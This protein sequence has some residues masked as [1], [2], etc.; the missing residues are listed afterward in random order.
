MLKVRSGDADPGAGGDLPAIASGPT[1]SVVSAIRRAAALYAVL[2]AVIAALALAALGYLVAQS[3]VQSRVTAQ[4]ESLRFTQQ[5]RVQAYFDNLRQVLQEAAARPLVIDGSKAL[6]REFDALRGTASTP[7]ARLREELSR[8]YT[9]D[10]A[11]EYERRNQAA[12]AGIAGAVAGLP[13][14]T[15]FAQSLYLSGNTRPLGRKHELGA[16]SDGS[17]Y[18]RVHAALQPLFDNLYRRFG[19]YDFFL[20]EPRSGW[21]VY[22]FFKEID[23]GTSLVDGPFARTGLGEAFQSLRTAT[24]RDAV[25]LADFAAYAPSYDEQ[26]AFISV[27]VFDAEGLVAVLIAQVP[28]DR[29]NQVMTFDGQWPQSGLG[30]TGQTWLVGRDSTPRSI[31]RAL[32]EDRARA[33][34]RIGSVSGADVATAVGRHASDI[35]TRPV[36]S[37]AVTDVLAGREGAGEYPGYGGVSTLGAWAPVQVLNQ[38]FGLIAEIDRAEALEPV[39]TLVWNI[40][41]AATVAAIALGMLAYLFAARIGRLVSEPLSR[42]RETVAELARGNLDARAGLDRTDEFGALGQ[43]LDKLLDERVESLGRS[44]MESEALN[45]SVIE[46]MQVAGSIAQTKDLTLRM[47]VHENV[48]GAISDALNLLTDETG[49]V[50]RNV[51]QVSHQVADATRAAKGQADNAVRAAAREQHEV[52]AAARE[53][54]QAAATLNAI[55]DRARACNDVAERAQG[56]TRE[57]MAVVGSTVSG[58]IESRDLIRETEKR[59]K[60]LGERSQEIGQVVGII[61][62]IA[63]RT[64]ILALNASMHAAAAGEAGRSFVVV[65]DEVKR[66]SESAREAT[67]QIGRLVTAIQTETGETMIA[68]NQ[69]I[70]K[71]VDISRLADDAGRSMRQ[72]SDQAEELAGEVR[73][74]ARTSSEQARVGN[75]LQERARIIQE[76][77]AE[78]AAQL[79]AQAVETRR[80]VEYAKSLLDEVS[81][82]KLE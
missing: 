60:R 5:Q 56:A 45:D 28:V 16:A 32:V 75:A 69:A 80:L 2:P 50:L 22:S 59:I 62:A 20:V 76:A 41:A 24:R 55:A 9:E 51:T 54:A 25:H 57:A 6:A 78:T 39:S 34:A 11:R 14:E 67:S 71:V 35:G 77:S 30:S 18:S 63:E 43:A 82:F 36:A 38:R 64:G 58:I 65:A 53:L 3:A 73:D 68:M 19:Y 29:L 72:T 40:A 44:E 10:Y 33:L 17:E 81:V 12:P 23:F 7:I 49:R 48:T 47:P 46:I 27:P 42:L 15:V 4:L 1:S 70:G 61:Q 13:D 26:A 66:L 52:R 79:T 8:Y 31:H 21:V 37:N 74:I